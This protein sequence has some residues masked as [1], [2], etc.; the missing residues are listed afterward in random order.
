MQGSGV[1]EK[2]IDRAMFD[3]ESERQRK[4]HFG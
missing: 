2:R 3:G 1:M 4:N